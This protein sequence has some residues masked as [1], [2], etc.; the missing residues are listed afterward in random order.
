MLAAV[1]GVD[2][3]FLGEQHDD[4][5]THRLE[6][7]TLEGLARR[8]SNAI[9]TEATLVL[10]PT[11]GGASWLLTFG[12]EHIDAIEAPDVMRAD[13]AVSGSSSELYL[14]L[15]NRPSPVEVSGDGSVAAL[16]RNVRVRWS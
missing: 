4:P 2:V 11:D 3:L 5:G 8:R 13:A 7:A 16:W 10:R 12:G 15:W 1:S 6:A 9:A 14:W